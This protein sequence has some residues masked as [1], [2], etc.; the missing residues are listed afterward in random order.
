MPPRRS[1]RKRSKSCRYAQKANGKCM[2][3]KEYEARRNERGRGI[4]PDLPPDIEKY[5]TSLR[6]TN[7]IH[8]YIENYD[9]EDEEET[10]SA[11]RKQGR[12]YY[13]T[14][15]PNKR[16]GSLAALNDFLMHDDTDKGRIARNTVIMRS[17]GQRR[18]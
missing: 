5:I 18:R 13:V 2:S 4:L 16:F 10:N 7:D 1:H 3:K 14:S 12:Y 17:R 8:R 11:I 6:R 15:A 9:P